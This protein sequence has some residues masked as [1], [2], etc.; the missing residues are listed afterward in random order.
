MTA[1]HDGQPAVLG[2][3]VIKM[4]AQSEQL[5]QNS[6]CGFAIREAMS[7]SNISYTREAGTEWNRNDKILMS[8]NCP[9]RVRTLV[10]EYRVDCK[11][12]ASQGIFRD[13]VEIELGEEQP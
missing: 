3:R 7:M 10:E 13:A 11:R 2:T 6:G 4:N 5:L 8:W 9:V 12:R 1:V